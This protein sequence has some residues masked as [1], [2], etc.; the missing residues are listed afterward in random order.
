MSP[1]QRPHYLLPRHSRTSCPHPRYYRGNF[2]KYVHITAALY[3]K[4]T[5]GH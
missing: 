4:V 2:T 1:L 5:Q 3:F